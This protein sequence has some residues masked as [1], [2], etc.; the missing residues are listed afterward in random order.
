MGND[1]SDADQQPGVTTKPMPE[2]E[3]APAPEL[4]EALWPEAGS[5]TV[6]GYGP[7]GTVHRASLSPMPSQPPSPGA[8]G[9]EVHSPHS[10]AVPG[11]RLRAA[12]ITLA[13]L[14]LFSPV[15]LVM[16]AFSLLA[17]SSADAGPLVVL[18]FVVAALLPFASLGLIIAAGVVARRAHHPRKTPGVALVFSSLSIF[19]VMGLLVLL[20]G[21]PALSRA[22]SQ[23]QAVLDPPPFQ[24][25]DSSEPSGP[26]WQPVGDPTVPETSLTEAELKSGM[27]E[28]LDSAVAAAGSTALWVEPMP[29]GSEPNATAYVETVVPTLTAVPCLGTGV[30]YPLPP[31]TFAKGIIT[32]TSS[33]EADRDVTARNVAAAERIVQN[34]VDRGYSEEGGMGGSIMLAGPNW[35]PAQSLKVR[36]SF[37]F[38][39]LSG[40]SRCV[41]PG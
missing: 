40:E 26:E 9:P 30:S 10:P 35:A 2:S 12:G 4:D 25:A 36:Y 38:V 39:T 37:G 22:S 3:S 11:G 32:D 24:P 18:Q 5:A 15:W 17:S 1:E 13:V 31:V 33:D 23:H 27:Q 34:W 21:I 14:S 7:P 29:A 19:G 41:V 20:F 28:L 8:E 16:L 6:Q